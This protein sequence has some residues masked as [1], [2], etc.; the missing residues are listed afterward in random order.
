[1]AYPATDDP[2]VPDAA[3]ASNRPAISSPIIS[4][5]IFSP[6]SLRLISVLISVIIRQLF[7]RFDK[8]GC[9][10]SFERQP[11]T[12]LTHD[13]LFQRLNEMDTRIA[14]RH[15]RSLQV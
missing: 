15:F 5:M 7:F 1:M 14:A 4:R 6:A 12:N 8:I 11:V 3:D 13:A 10:R 9:R 2:N